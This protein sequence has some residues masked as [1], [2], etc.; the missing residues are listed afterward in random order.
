LFGEVLHA[1]LVEDYKTKG[2][3]KKH[4]IAQ[5]Q[6]G[7]IIRRYRMLRES[8]SFLSPRVSRKYRSISSEPEEGF[9]KQQSENHVPKTSV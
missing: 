1:E 4:T 9:V 6:S 7:R 2:L 8:K 3:K 5:I